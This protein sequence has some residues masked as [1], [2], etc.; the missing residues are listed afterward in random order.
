[1]NLEAK[2]LQPNEDEVETIDLSKNDPAV[3]VK[4]E[5]QDDHFVNPNS[6]NDFQIISCEADR[7]SGNSCIVTADIQ[8]HT[9]GKT[10][11]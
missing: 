3:E 7:N 6:S 1:M 2:D 10:I 11:L 9:E 8:P 4:C 5:T